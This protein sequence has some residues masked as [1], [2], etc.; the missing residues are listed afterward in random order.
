[1][2]YTSPGNWKRIIEKWNKRQPLWNYQQFR[3]LKSNQRTWCIYD[4][5]PVITKLVILLKITRKQWVSSQVFI[6]SF[7]TILSFVL[8]GWGEGGLQ[9]FITYLDWTTV[10]GFN[11]IQKKRRNNSK[12]ENVA[13]VCFMAEKISQLNISGFVAYAFF[14]YISYFCCSFIFL[15][16][17]LS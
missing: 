14:C 5:V 17:S 16:G 7:A 11:R 8:E 6:M 15:L 2:L 4:R 9:I 13:K 10:S 12:E 3:L 1:M